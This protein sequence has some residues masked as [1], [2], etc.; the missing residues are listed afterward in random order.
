MFLSRVQNLDQLYFGK[1]WLLLPKKK[2][3]EHCAVIHNLWLILELKQIILMLCLY[4]QLI[5]S[6]KTKHSNFLASYR[7]DIAADMY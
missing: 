4:Q 5:L 1:S 2:K 3:Y 6:E 7:I